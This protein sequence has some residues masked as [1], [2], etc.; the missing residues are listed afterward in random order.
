MG[1]TRRRVKG[2]LFVDTLLEGISF[3]LYSTRSHVLGRDSNSSQELLL[4]NQEFEQQRT[5]GTEMDTFVMALASASFSEVSTGLLVLLGINSV[6]CG[7][8][9]NQLK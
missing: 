2:R 9:T 1:R 6:F 5:H 8:R 7:Q 4:R 3:S